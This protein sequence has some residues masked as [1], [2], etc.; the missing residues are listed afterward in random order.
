[1]PPKCAWSPPDY[2]V[3][4]GR[5][6]QER[7][8]PIGGSCIQK[9]DVICGNPLRGIGGKVCTSTRR[10]SSLPRHAG[11]SSGETNR[12]KNS[13]LGAQLTPL[14]PT[15]AFGTLVAVSS[16]AASLQ[17]YLRESP[18]GGRAPRWPPPTRRLRLCKALTGCS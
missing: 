1:M 18:S 10:C 8:I 17:Y 15:R 14:F 3:R 11:A 5:R 12:P 13:R 6:G 7:A 16:R 4:P 2:C 9:W